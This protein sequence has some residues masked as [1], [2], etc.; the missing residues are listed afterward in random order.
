M[1]PEKRGNDAPPITE[2]NTNMKTTH[3]NRIALIGLLATA[4]T[5]PLLAV[6]PPAPP[7]RPDPE[8]VVVEMLGDY[9]AN[10]SAT[11]DATELAAAFDGI[12]AKHQAERQAQRPNAGNR[13]NN[14]NNNP[15]RPR[16][17]PGMRGPRNPADLA[18]QLIADFDKD[19]DAALNSEE[20]YRAITFLHANRP[21]R[22]PRGPLPA[23]STE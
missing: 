15:D 3:A 18:P 21:G 13:D 10:D 7:V 23:E 16:K 9:D 22:G 1:L 6:D 20:L 12:R 8:T 4:F 5:A 14:N 19:A 17:G 2:R 11:L